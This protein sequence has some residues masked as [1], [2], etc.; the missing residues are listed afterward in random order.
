MLENKDQSFLSTKCSDNKYNGRKEIAGQYSSEQKNLVTKCTISL[1]PDDIIDHVFI[2]MIDSRTL[3]LLKCTN[4]KWKKRIENYIEKSAPKFEYKNKFG[5]YGM[6]NGQFVYPKYVTIDKQD[7]IYVSEFLSHRIQIFDSKGQWKQTIGAQGFGDGEFDHP[8]GITVNSEDCLIV[9]DRGN[10][11]VQVFNKNLN[12]IESFGPYGS[13]RKRLLYPHAIT[14]DSDD[15]IYVVNHTDSIIIY[16]RNGEWKKTIDMYKEENC[17]LKSIQD[18]VVDKI[19][20][21]IFI[22]NNFDHSIGVLS[23]SGKLLFKFAH[24]TQYKYVNR[25]ALTNCGKYLLVSDWFNN[26]IDVFYTMNGS[27][28]KRYGTEGSKDG[29]FKHPQGICVSPSGQIIVCD[30]GN[31]RIQIFE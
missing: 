1:L 13:I 17:K 8:S 20:S 25:L 2:S 27:F 28:I 24:Y 15:N 3:H 5:S 19:G 14:V 16:N 7:N 10:N 23:P 9:V 26:S 6:N 21:R 4:S 31:H 11:R 22:Y 12:F 29:Q 30:E 18:I